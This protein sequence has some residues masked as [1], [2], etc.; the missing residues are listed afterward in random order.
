MKTMN[1]KGVIP[2]I[3]SMLSLPIIIVIAVTLLIVL[4]GV[5]WFLSQYLF[6]LIGAALLIGFV[7]ALIKGRV[8][9]GVLWAVAIALLVLPYVFTG[10]KEI[11]LI[12]IVG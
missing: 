4:V 3:I 6:T 12:S 10:L 8:I 7:W 9:H 2:A 11:T 1:K 5:G